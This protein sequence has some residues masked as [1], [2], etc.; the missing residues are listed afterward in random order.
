MKRKFDLLR[1]A[2][3]KYIEEANPERRV[4]KRSRLT[5]LIAAV[6]SLALLVGA[7]SVFLLPANKKDEYNRP[8]G[9]PAIQSGI[10]TYLESHGKYTRKNQTSQGGFWD[11][12]FNMFGGGVKGEATDGVMNGDFLYGGA[13]EEEVRDDIVA[14]YLETYNPSEIAPTPDGTAGDKDNSSVEVTDNQVEGVSEGDRFKRSHTHIFYLDVYGVL[15]VYTIEVTELD[16]ENTAL[17]DEDTVKIYQSEKEI[18]EENFTVDIPGISLV[19]IE[20]LK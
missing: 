4:R 12:L 3:D 8:Q 16:L 13:V 7:L 5:V 2:D 19:V 14:D 6:P 11:N 1:Y 9:Y 18:T 10:T 17:V 20:L 15:K